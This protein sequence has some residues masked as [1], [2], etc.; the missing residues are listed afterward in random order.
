M[1]V[2]IGFGT[3]PTQ[4]VLNIREWTGRHKQKPRITF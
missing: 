2:L 1:S 3:G 4:T